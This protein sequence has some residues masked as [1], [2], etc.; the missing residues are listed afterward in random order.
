[1]GNHIVEEEHRSGLDVISYPRNSRGMAREK[2]DITTPVSIV[3]RVRGVNCKRAPLR[4]H[5][6]L[7]TDDLQ[8]EGGMDREI[9]GFRVWEGDTRA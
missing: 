7:R 2:S 4:E 6:A 3:R 5:G 9:D 8:A 1:M